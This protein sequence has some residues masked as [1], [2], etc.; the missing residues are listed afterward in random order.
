MKIMLANE[1]GICHK[2]STKVTTPKGNTTQLIN[3]I[4]IMSFKVKSCYV[5]PYNAMALRQILEI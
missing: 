3:A 2:L 5:G 1:L 4:Y